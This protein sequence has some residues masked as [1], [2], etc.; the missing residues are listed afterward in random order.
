MTCLSVLERG[1]RGNNNETSLEQ[2][3]VIEMS[4]TVLSF[5]LTIIKNLN[6]FTAHD[7][8]INT[9]RIN[10]TRPWLL[11]T[12]SLDRSVKLWDI[13]RMS[14]SSSSSA[15]TCK[16]IYTLNH[17]LAV[18]SAVFSPDGTQMLFQLV[19]LKPENLVI[20]NLLQIHQQV[21]YLVRFY[22]RLVLLYWEVVT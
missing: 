3:E 4:T 17:E 12:A 9:L 1:E 7:K 15:S 10:P 13:R 2:G 5:T 16:P 19:C 21:V 8:K 6:Y 22:Y 18:S 14:K 20:L 11:A